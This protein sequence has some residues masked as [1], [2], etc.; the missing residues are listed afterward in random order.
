MSGVQGV[1]A[2]DFAESCSLFKHRHRGENVNLVTSPATT[3][4]ATLFEVKRSIGRLI[5]FSDASVLRIFN[6]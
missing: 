6:D 5:L 4:A 2:R 1:A 3:T